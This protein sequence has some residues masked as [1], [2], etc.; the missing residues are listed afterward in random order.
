MANGEKKSKL[1]L[2]VLLGFGVAL[3]AVAIAAMINFTSLNR[4][5]S[6]VETISQ[7]DYK[8][9]CLKQLLTDLSDL[10][11]D[12]RTYTLTHD[13]KYLDAYHGVADS[14]EQ[15]IARLKNLTSDND[16]QSVLTDSIERL[17]EERII[18][19]N[20][21]IGKRKNEFAAKLDLP[22]PGIKNEKATEQQ[23]VV[24]TTV[25][26]PPPSVAVPEKNENWWSRN[27]GSKKKKKKQNEEVV[28]VPAEVIDS[29]NVVADRTDSVNDQLSITELNAILEREKEK[30]NDQV[31]GWSLDELILLQQDKLVMDKIRSAINLLEKDEEVIA[32]HQTN[33]AATVA[34][35]ST[36]IITIITSLGI[37]S[38]LL[39]LFLI[40]RDISKSN[41]L[42]IQLIEERKRAEKLAKVK[43]EFLANMSHEI[44]TPL[45]AIVGFTEQLAKEETGETQRNYVH[46]I[47][48]SAEYLSSLVNQVL[49]FSKIESGKLKAQHVAFDFY[50]LVRE[51]FEIFRIKASEK[52]TLF[53]YSIEEMV[54]RYVMGD[55]IICRQILINLVSNAI[56][57]TERGSVN[58]SCSAKEP[59]SHDRRYY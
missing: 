45:N 48:H 28:A 11:G 19:F 13:E 6:A 56:K 4:L 21:F 55:P 30:L 5:L 52:S 2:K 23:P 17:V 1:Q 14:I 39:F 50:Q 51:V 49:S 34:H 40:L 32:M 44:R 9:I 38:I 22:E 35:D 26:S 57:F 31:E 25:P 27:F 33:E 12:V 43:E 29:L 54:P 10:E 58:I 20:L 41:R 42:K 7:P 53:S 8:L 47:H 18:L 24:V 59:I 46:A 16:K 36:M 3:I 37:L 15:R